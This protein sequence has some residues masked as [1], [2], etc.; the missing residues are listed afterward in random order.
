[1]LRAMAA[2]RGTRDLAREAARGVIGGVVGSGAMILAAHLRRRRYAR[3]HGIAPDEIDV[4]LDYD[5]SE[6]VVIA[7]STLLRHVVGWAPRSERGRQ[8]LFW[9][10]HWG[11]G[12]AAGAVHVGLA[13]AIARGR[14]RAAGPDRAVEPAAG[15]AFFA[16]TEA[17]ALGLFP[18][19]GGTPPPWRWEQG[20]LRTSAV[21]HGI[22]AG[23]V[24]AANTLTTRAGR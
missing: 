17:M 10:V 4:V 6:Y 23:T 3:Q 1:M 21:Q 20:L 2:R 5:D 12:S 8:V 19:L 16:V 11:Y 24:A 13:R 22:Y 9:L 14:R 18:A 15:L 7:A